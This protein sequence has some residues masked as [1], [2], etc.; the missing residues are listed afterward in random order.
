MVDFV[1]WHGK[2]LS[3]CVALVG[4]WG[5]RDYRVMPPRKG[6]AFEGLSGCLGIFASHCR[7][8]AVRFLRWLWRRPI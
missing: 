8:R 2:T 6:E 4:Q 3:E 5:E 7:G 1:G